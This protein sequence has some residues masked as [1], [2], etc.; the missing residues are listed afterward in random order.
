[1]KEDIKEFINNPTGKIG[2]GKFCKECGRYN[3]RHITCDIIPV[4]E[5]NK[6]LLTLRN[7]EPEKN[8]WSLPGGYVGWDE[9]VEE[10]ARR[11]LYEETG[12]KA[13]KIKFLKVYSNP[14]R[15]DGRQNITLCHVATKLKKNSDFDKEEVKEIKWFSMDDLPE[16]AFD[17]RNMIEEYLNS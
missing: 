12:Y 1:M 8:K 13:G 11:E 5:D 10:C 7:I 9:T 6:I 17:H 15:D 2:K 4:K 3:D 14:N 16:L